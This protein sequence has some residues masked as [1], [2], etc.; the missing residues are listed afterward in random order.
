MMA[1]GVAEQV[2]C[3]SPSRMLN[4]GFQTPVPCRPVTG[5]AERG[6]DT[7]RRRIHLEPEHR[8]RFRRRPGI[9]LIGA[10]HADH[11]FDPDGKPGLRT[12]RGE[13]VLTP[14]VH[15]NRQET[16]P[17]GR[18]PLHADD[19]QQPASE[20]DSEGYRPRV[21][22]QP[23]R[24]LLAAVPVHVHRDPTP[25]QPTPTEPPALNPHVDRSYFR[26]ILLAAP[27]I[28]YADATHEPARRHP[29]MSPMHS[30]TTSRSGWE[31]STIAWAAIGNSSSMSASTT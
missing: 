12:E 21:A 29:S 16:A 9:Q 2:D 22:V 13:S 20:H 7:N 10:Q 4:C 8:L 18:I 25:A 15:P 14:P 30:S 3:H 28:S 27:R 31:P 26:F 5:A 17:P 23:L 6:P 11:G 1:R 24:A 19:F